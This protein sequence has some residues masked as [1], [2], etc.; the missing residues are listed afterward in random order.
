MA[1]KKGGFLRSFFS[2]VMGAV[3]GAVGGLLLAPRA[4]KETLEQLKTKGE[5][6]IETGKKSALDKSGELR[7]KI[8]ETTKKLRKKVETIVEAKEEKTEKA[9]GATQEKSG[10]KTK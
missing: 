10:K 8:D 4:G 5:E 3:A 1:E 6:L 9:A 2:F 7:T